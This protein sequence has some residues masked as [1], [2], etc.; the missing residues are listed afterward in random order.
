MSARKTIESLLQ[1]TLEEIISSE[2]SLSLNDTPPI[3]VE[4]PKNPE[5]GD[6]SC[7]LAFQLA[8]Q[9]IKS[10]QVIGEMIITILNNHLNKNFYRI[11]NF[12]SSRIYQF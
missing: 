2:N 11:S 9:L 7:N 6:Y 10:P 8:P 1:E 5:H 4:R 12:S 3:H